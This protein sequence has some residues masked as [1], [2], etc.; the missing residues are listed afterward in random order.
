[1][2]STATCC[3]DPPIEELK[4]RE[5]FNYDWVFGRLVWTR[6]AHSR[7]FIRHITMISTQ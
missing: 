1:M 5:A 7:N 3:A 2:G 6:V 4:G